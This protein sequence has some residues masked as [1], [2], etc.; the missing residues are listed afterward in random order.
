MEIIYKETAAELLVSKKE[1]AAQVTGEL[2][3]PD[4]RSVNR[5]LSAVPGIRL[6]SISTENGAVVFEGRITVSVNALDLNDELFSYNS[7]ASFRQSVEIPEADKGMTAKIASSVRS[8]TLAPSPN[9]ASMEAEVDFDIRVLSAAPVRACMGAKDADDIE[10]KTRPIKT[11]IKRYIGTKTLD[12]R[13]EITVDEPV[14][15]ISSESTVNIK[16]VISDQGG[17]VVSGSITVSAVTLDSRGGVSQTVK[18]IPFREHLSISIDGD[19]VFCKV[20]N[21]SVYLRSLGDDFPMIAIEAQIELEFF[22]ADEFEA[23]MP[24]DMF[25]PTCGIS[26]VK[27]D[28]MLYNERGN[29]CVQTTMKD[30]VE[31]PENTPPIKEILYA[32]AVPVVTGAV[33]ERDGITVNGILSTT[34]AYLSEYGI[35]DSF[36]TNVDFQVS[37]PVVTPSESSDIN[38]ECVASAVMGGDRN[39][40]IQY[41]LSVAADIVSLDEVSIVT[42]LAEAPVKVNEPGIMIIFASEGEDVFDI[43][44][45]FSVSCK[46]VRKLNPDVAEPFK[47]GDKLLIMV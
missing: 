7:G 14:G 46:S 43:A 25:S 17:A 9:G 3:S 45:R 19:G 35:K 40:Q 11:Y 37:L 12:L 44:K 23:E 10:V 20:N 30:S 32:S 26:A 47:D 39:V 15:V 6:N 4:G 34:V 36:K 24:V 22:A 2:P 41:F 33:C 38:A 13:E 42:S 28:L 16:D 31:V 29:V 21:S 27:E 1:L 18:Q 8:I 5:V